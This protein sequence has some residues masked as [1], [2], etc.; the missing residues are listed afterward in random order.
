MKVIK[1]KDLQEM[2][3][4]P[5]YKNFIQLIRRGV[6]EGILTVDPPLPPEENENSPLTKEKER[7]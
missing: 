3:K 6:A 2:I 5:E 1:Y 7:R 4:S